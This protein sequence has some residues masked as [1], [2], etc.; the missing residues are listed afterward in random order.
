LLRIY[1]N[2]FQRFVTNQPEFVEEREF[3]SKQVLAWLQGGR[4]SY[5]KW[6]LVPK[7][8]YAISD[9]RPLLS[10]DRAW[11]LSSMCSPRNPADIEQLLVLSA[12]AAAEQNRFPKWFEI[13]SL[14]NYFRGMS[15]E[16][17]GAS[18]ALWSYAYSLQ[19]DKESIPIDIEQASPNQLKTVVKARAKLGDVDE[20]VTSCIHKLHRSERHYRFYRKGEI[21]GDKPPGIPKIILELLPHLKR[22]DLQ[23]VLKY[24]GGFHSSGW[25]ADLLYMYVAALLENNKTQ[26]VEELLQQKLGKRDRQIVLRA[27]A[28]SSILQR[29]HGWH[30]VLKRRVRSMDSMSRLL[31]VAL[32]RNTDKSLS[33]EIRLP[34]HEDFPEEVPDYKSATRSWRAALFIDLFSKAALLTLG[35]NDAI[36]S[37]WLSQC[38]DHWHHIAAQRLVWLGQ[39]VARNLANETESSIQLL[40]ESFAGLGMLT[41]SD[42]REQIEIQHSLSA[43]ITKLAEIF[44]LIRS[45]RGGAPHLDTLELEAILSIP[46]LNHHQF[47]VAISES[48]H[49]WLTPEACSHLLESQQKITRSQITNPSER[50]ESLSTL[51]AIASLHSN[52]A[53]LASLTEATADNLIAYGYRDML[54]YEVIEATRLLHQVA[55]DEENLRRLL[56]IAS[57][58]DHVREYAHGDGIE[59]IEDSYTEALSE[60]SQP[61]LRSRLHWLLRNESWFRADDAF[62]ALVRKLNLDD[63]FD[64]ALASTA[65]EGLSRAALSDR[66]QSC[67]QARTTLKGIESRYQ[68]FA[69]GSDSNLEEPSK[70]NPSQYRNQEQETI[71]QVPPTKLVAWVGRYKDMR[72]RRQFLEEWESFWSKPDSP[73]RGSALYEVVKDDDLSELPANV[74][75]TL[76]RYLYSI[77]KELAFDVLCHAQANG[78]GWSWTL[79][80]S[81]PAVE[82]WNFLKNTMPARSKEFL[83]RSIKYGAERS[84]RYQFSH[85]YFSFPLLLGVRFLLLFGEITLCKE[86]ITHATTIGTQLCADLPL[87]TSAWTKTSIGSIDLLMAR[88]SDR[89]PFV[90]E[91]AASAVA[92]LLSN[93]P[94]ANQMWSSLEEWLKEN[95]L[96]S[97]QQRALCAVLKA[98]ENGVNLRAEKLD[99]IRDAVGI[100]SRLTRCIFNLLGI[101]NPQAADSSALDAPKNDAPGNPDLLHFLRS[102]AINYSPPS[103]MFAYQQWGFTAVRYW[104]EH[105]ASLVKMHDVPYHFGEF[106]EYRGQAYRDVLFGMTPLL[107]DAYLTGHLRLIETQSNHFD[108]ESLLDAELKAFPIDLSYWRATPGPKPVNWPSLKSQITDVGDIDR[109]DA[110]SILRTVRD[111]DEHKVLHMDGPVTAAPHMLPKLTGLYITLIAFAYKRVGTGKPSAERLF[112]KLDEVRIQFPLIEAVNPCAVLDNSSIW[113]ASGDESFFSAD[114]EIF[115]LSARLDTPVDNGWQ[116]YRFLNEPT[117]VTPRL[118]KQPQINQFVGGWDYS[119]GNNVIQFRDWLENMEERVPA[120]LGAPYGNSLSIGTDTLHTWLQERGM[121]LGYVYRLKIISRK[122]EYQTKPT[123]RYSYGI[124]DLSNLIL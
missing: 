102:H 19:Q 36:V 111:N 67:E 98:A 31:C 14:L 30:S 15:D 114:I 50:A 82:R 110:E 90:R 25:D 20:L 105:V 54:W 21:G 66:A 120:A 62:A 23:A 47:L 107:S 119:D 118:M 33:A 7:L 22:H 16:A 53:A 122:D 97:A 73:D 32:L 26:K 37:R 6:L 12:Y 38:D 123:Q 86:L 92:R 11:L 99:A 63:P 121:R 18:D 43:A 49:T 28:I 113:T 46:Q 4:F 124:V 115:P 117:V 60:I 100:P 3:I 108:A 42:H 34:N 71:A 52:D 51:A 87:P 94:T 45:S 68:I 75:D 81:D 88:L 64:E 69:G 48:A 70:S 65:I 59:M 17:P 24:V 9:F 76:S 56:A 44:L 80:P 79:R 109:L 112:G 61:A 91:L 95:P 96:E 13:S 29:N 89:G 10:M 93:S 8:S 58:V 41:F 77:D 101:P 40:S 84:Q 2:S 116:W 85:D 39:Q 35:G 55:H 78:F 57:Q 74:L 72:E 103:L 1:H 5:L 106:G 83:V 27:V 104:I